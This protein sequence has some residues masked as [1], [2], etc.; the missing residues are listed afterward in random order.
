MNAKSPP[1][2]AATDLARLVDLAGLGPR[3]LE[4][5]GPG[6]ADLAAELE[7]AFEPG[8]GDLEPA[9][10]RATRL[11]DLRPDQARE[12]HRAGLW[13]EAA[14]RSRA[15]FL[16]VPT[17]FQRPF[18]G[19]APD[20]AR[21]AADA[22]LEVSAEPHPRAAPGD[23]PPGGTPPP[24]LA[25]DATALLLA[26]HT[27][28]LTVAEVLDDHLQRLGPP[29]D[30]TTGWALDPW[31]ALV[32]HRSEDELRERAR[33]LDRDLAAK[34]AP[35]LAGLPFAVKANLACEGLETTAASRA[36]FGWRAPYTATV[37]R[38]LVAAG[39]MPVATANMDEFAMGS[40]GEH[41]A[42]GAT[43]NPWSPPGDPRAP[44]GSSSGSAASVAADLVPL[45]LGSDAGGSVRQPAALCGVTGLRPSRGR[46][47]RFG[48][49]AFASGFDTVGPVAQSA[50][51]LEL[52]L[53]V[54]AGADPRDA[55]AGA[56]AGGPDFATWRGLKVGVP[57][58]LLAGLGDGLEPAVG[59]SFD[60]AL[61]ELEDLGAELVD[62]ELTSAEAALSAYH[63]SSCA[64]AASNLARFDGARFGGRPR[65][66]AT[67]PA[68]SFEELVVR[69]RDAGFGSEVKRR[70]LI[71]TLALAKPREARRSGPDRRRLF[72][73][74][75]ETRARVTTEFEAAF[76]RC[77]L[78]AM[79]TSPTR[80]FALGARLA[81]PMAMYR[82]D[83]LTVPASLAGLAAVSLPG[84]ARGGLPVGIQLLAAVG[85]DE[86][87]LAAA[88]AWQAAHP[89]HLRRP[90]EVLG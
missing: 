33:G 56:P 55:T 3:T 48:L 53:A 45:A 20:Q 64:E 58:R 90:G 38:R 25:P 35:P 62:I 6:L 76:A 9:P 86:R 37:V 57:R 74:A 4:E 10:P 8:A 30:G 87:L 71:G 21:G 88:A 11:A 42:H 18:G 23:L 40:S 75:A 54:M 72:A 36:L 16:E 52:V 15:G 67:R 2:P 84:P 22:R 5:F 68:A 26:L 61:A 14:P 44:G 39:A 31:R 1:P 79:P 51:D 43:L 81:D 34:E 73:A 12:R 50:R 83:L 78:V 59:R 47:S 66:L 28:E 24:P 60:A 80:A 89:H 69:A 27:G 65:D 85:Q 29:G 49:V 82:A 63:V 70:I 32:A 7:A 77:D 13:L 19:A 17:A 46:L 41:S